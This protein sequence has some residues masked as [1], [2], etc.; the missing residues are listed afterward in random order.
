VSFYDGATLLGTKTAVGGTATLV[1]KALG[2]GDHAIT[3]SAAGFVTSPALTQRVDPAVTA[4]TLTSVVNPSVYGQT[5]TWKVTVKRQ[6]PAAGT[7]TTGT[8]EFFDDGTL[9]ATK[10]VASGAAALSTKALHAG[11]HPIT[12]VYNGSASDLG[13]ASPTLTQVVDPASTTV[14]LTTTAG[15]TSV[16]G[17]AVPLKAVVTRN[18]PSTGKATGTVDFY[19]ELGPIRLGVPLSSGGVATTTV[20]GLPVGTHVIHVDYGGS[21]DQLASN[22]SVVQ[23]VGPAATATKLTASPLTTTAGHLVKL[24]ITVKAQAPSTTVPSGQVTILDGTNPVAGATLAAGK[25]VIST[26]WPTA[27]T[28]AL[29]AVYAGDGDCNGSVSAAV[30]VSV[31]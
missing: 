2:L 29:V 18:A 21:T 26:S 5:T 15:A 9:L 10:P 1:T 6:P 28:H 11:S 22:A 14:A 31:A 24:T 30:T 27:G 8:V 16:F 12:A 7:V 13:S 19:D 17:Q 23:T 3:V 4:T 25:A 20:T